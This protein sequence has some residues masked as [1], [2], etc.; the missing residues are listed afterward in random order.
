MQDYSDPCWGVGDKNGGPVGANPPSLKKM[1]ICL[2]CGQ[3]RTFSHFFRYSKSAGNIDIC[4]DCD[5]LFRRIQKYG[6]TL[7][8]YDEMFHAQGGRCAGCG[9]MPTSD[10][11]L[12][13]DHCHKSSKVR[14]LLCS[15]C[16]LALGNAKDNTNT[17]KNLIVY[18]E[19]AS[20]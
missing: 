6:I 17:L 12:A 19:K 5:R 13:I 16:N 20:T 18:L 3:F 8:E 10:K 1:K 14:G 11:P 15:N 9:I 7:K 2:M 4:I